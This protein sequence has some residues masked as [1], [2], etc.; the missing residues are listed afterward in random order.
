MN[1][2]EYT[3]EKIKSIKYGLCKAMS[4]SGLSPS[5]AESILSKSAFDY[6]QLMTTPVAF[7]IGAGALG[8]IGTAAA[9]IN[10]E[11]AIDNEEDSEVR[12][13]KLRV[14]MYKKM[15][16]DLKADMAAKKVVV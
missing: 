1:S 16:D 8:G 4:E 13:D 3:E 12:K 9:R 14:K 11:H 6:T 15:I 7:A 5:E 10:I 2:T